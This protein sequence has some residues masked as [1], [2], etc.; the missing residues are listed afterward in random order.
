MCVCGVCECVGVCV[1]VCVGCVCVRL[2]PVAVAP[3]F[4]LHAAPATLPPECVCVCGGGGVYTCNY[5][6][7]EQKIEVL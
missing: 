6:S 2:S 1:C 4:W 3:F 7:G 5:V